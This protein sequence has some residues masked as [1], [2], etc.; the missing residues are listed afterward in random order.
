LHDKPESLVSL[1][2]GNS[3]ASNREL[4]RE[5]SKKYEKTGI[6]IIAYDFVS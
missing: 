3:D 6:F 5:K 2:G 4:K 1:P